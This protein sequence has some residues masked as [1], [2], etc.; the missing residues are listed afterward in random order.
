MKFVDEATIRVEAGDGGN[1]CSSFRREKYIPNGGPDGG[2][3]GNG[4][5]VYIVGNEGLNTLADYRFNRMQ[6]GERGQNGMSRDKTGRKGEHKFIPVP[7]GTLAYDDETDELIGEIVRDG[8]ELLVA[9]GGYH[10]LGNVRFKSSTNRAPRRITNGTVGESR[11]LRM[12]LKVLADVG[13]LGMPNAGKSSLI[14]AISAATP[15]VA[16]YPFTTLYPNLGVVRVD[17]SRSFVVADIPGVIEG[18]AEGAGLGIQFLKHLS[19]NRVLL[20][21]LDAAPL[22]GVAD[23]VDEFRKIEHELEKFSA[24]LAAIPRWL[25][26]NKLDL[27]PEEERDSVCADIVEQL[28]WK[29]PLFKISALKRDGTEPLVYAIMDSLE[30]ADES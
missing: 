19:R 24:D 12:E 7:I 8:E 18:A 16:D 27:L 23:P 3:G 21:I 30:E 26:L 17:A 10:G 20:H 13:L 22:D 29:G 5:S 11:F 15:R 28:S 1:G 9:R 2:D 14:R 6:R 25:V 4:G